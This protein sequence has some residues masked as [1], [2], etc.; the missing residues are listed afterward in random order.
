LVG[1]E[2]FPVTGPPAIGHGAHFGTIYM[3]YSLVESWME[4][5]DIITKNGNPAKRQIW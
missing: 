4:S 1:P 3:L 2:H 5:G